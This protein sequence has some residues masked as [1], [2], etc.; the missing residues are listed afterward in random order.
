ME[1]FIDDDIERIKFCICL[2]KNW[3]EKYVLDDVKFLF[4]ERFFEI[5]FR[6]EIREVMFEV[7]EWF[8]EYERFSVDELNNV[9]FDVVKKCG[10]LSKEW[11][12]V[13]YN[14]FIGKDRGLRLVLF[15][16]FLNREFVIKRLRLEG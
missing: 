12:K 11:F 7:V 1:N 15:L 8:E 6:F 14:I 4:F 16:V 5:E 13:F 2:V 9:I 10:I 3:V